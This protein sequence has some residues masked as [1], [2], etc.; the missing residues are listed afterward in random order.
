MSAA[1]I[2]VCTSSFSE[3]KFGWGSTSHAFIF[4]LHNKEGLSPFKSMVKNKA[5]AM[6]KKSDRGPVFGDDIVIVD[7]TNN[8]KSLSRFGSH[9]YVPNGVKIPHTILAGTQQF[10]PDE[11][12]VFYFG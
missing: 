4:S 12:E 2:C 6:L 7:N 10:S 1:H 8:F 11:L 5:Y 3:N 9:Y